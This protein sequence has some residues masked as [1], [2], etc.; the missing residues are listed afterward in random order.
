MIENITTHFSLVRKRNI[1]VGQ[2]CSHMVFFVLASTKYETYFFV[3]GKGV[4]LSLHAPSNCYVLALTYEYICRN[5][6]SAV[7]AFTLLLRKKI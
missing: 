4:T 1:G 6:P 2:H 7:D 3:D 5:N